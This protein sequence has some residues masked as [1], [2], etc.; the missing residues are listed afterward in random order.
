VKNNEEVRGLLVKQGIKPEELPPE[1]DI[2]KLERRVKST[3][4][5]LSSGSQK[6]TFT[7]NN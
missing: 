3:E 2:K 6:L 1:E 7:D 4:K 5:K